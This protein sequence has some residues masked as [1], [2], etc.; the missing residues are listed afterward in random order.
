MSTGSWSPKA[1]R[2]S[3]RFAVDYLFIYHV[4]IHFCIILSFIT[5]HSF[6]S[7]IYVFMLCYHLFVH[8][9]GARDYQEEDVNRVL[10]P[11]GARDVNPVCGLLPIHL[12]LVIYSFIS[13]WSMHLFIYHLLIY[14]HL[15]VLCCHLFIH[16]FGARDYREEHFD[17]VLI[18]QGTDVATATGFG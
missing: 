6:G 18:S 1:P 3:T 5:I 13:S 9:F 16:Y 10:I 12:S 14:Y 4:F 7:F 11:Q 17:R 8:D 2:K 15:F